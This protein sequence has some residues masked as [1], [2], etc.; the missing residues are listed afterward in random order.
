MRRVVITGIGVISPCGNS[1]DELYQSLITGF[2]GIVPSEVQ[3][4]N[5]LA[6]VNNEC[7]NKLSKKEKRYLD[8]T[9]Q[10]ALL[11]SREAVVDSDLNFEELDSNRVGISFGTSMGGYGT[12]REETIN[13][14]LQ[15]L[16]SLNVLGM[17]KSL[18]NLIGTNIS[19][20]FNCKG[21]V[22]TY[23]T[24]CASSSIAIG[25]GYRKIQAGELDVV[26]AGGSES[27]IYD[28][29][30]ESFN[31]LGALS[32]SEKLEEASIPFATK[33][34][35]FVLGEGSA[36]LILEDYEHALSRNAHIYCEINGYSVTS[37]AKSLV[38]PD[39]EGISL[40]L[41][42]A[43]K[44][45][46]LLPSDIEYINAH[47]TSTEANDRIESKAI[48]T[49]FKDSVEKPFVSSTKS[50]H[51]HLLGAA[52]ALEALICCLIIDNEVIFPQINMSESDVDKD[53]DLNLLLEKVVPYRG[54]S[55]M[56][57]SFAFGGANSTLIFSKLK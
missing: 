35:G 21:G 43:I 33:R 2:S 53:V 32:K 23:N 14:K 50:L 26:I 57:N 8:R 37:D 1:V 22:F 11:A 47:G 55:I 48:K 6:Q 27:C 19:M 36:I 49:I 16:D 3:N 9:A 25:E 54:G 42:K 15:G 17:P 4:A 30:L 12:L 44:R 28:E 7:L 52:G 56:S 20:E 39:F 18:H 29:V 31:K 38:A 45:A 41:D 24:A 51:G 10:F 34:S 13:S 46:K 40:C 5:F